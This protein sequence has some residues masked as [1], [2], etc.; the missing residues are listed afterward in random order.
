[1]RNAVVERFPGVGF[2]QDQRVAVRE[3]WQNMHGLMAGW[4]NNQFE[5]PGNVGLGLTRRA[6]AEIDCASCIQL[7]ETMLI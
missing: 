5:T 3:V 4:V 2:D 7:L 1:M 6:V